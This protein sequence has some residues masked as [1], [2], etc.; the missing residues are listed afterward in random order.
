VLPLGQRFNPLLARLAG[1]HLLIAVPWHSCWLTIASAWLKVASSA[2]APIY[3]TPRRQNPEF[4][5]LMVPLI[6][7]ARGGHIV[8]VGANIGVYTL[9]IRAISR[10]PIIAFEPDPALF[11]LLAH[12]VTANALRS[13]SLRN[14]ACGD[15]TGSLRFNGGINGAVATGADSATETVPVV[16][17]DDELQDIEAIALIK[18][19]CE[20]FEWNILHGCR[21]T[22]ETK[23]PALFVELHP[24][25]IGKYG[26]SLAEIL[27][28]L[29]P[30]Y[31]LA[32]WDLNPGQRSLSRALRFLSRYRQRLVRLAGEAEALALA[33]SDAAP[34]QL[35]MVALPRGPMP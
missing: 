9:N 14:C 31:E 26:H 25:L 22:I 17:L 27:T 10:A 8:D 3:Q 11:R 16:R 35:F 1:N 15:E 12:N 13:V 4:F 20:G 21:R 19:D 29:R 5:K 33:A 34:D 24:K 30:H 23:R 2:G 32:F 7:A 18:I 28:L 6:D